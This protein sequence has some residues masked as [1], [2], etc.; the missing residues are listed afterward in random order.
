MFSNKY[1]LNEEINELKMQN[2]TREKED[3]T[4]DRNLLFLPTLGND[5]TGSL[6]RKKQDIVKNK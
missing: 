2:L 6:V 5:F 1:L 3:Q 4:K